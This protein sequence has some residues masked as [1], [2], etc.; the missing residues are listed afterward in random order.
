MSMRYDRIFGL[1]IVFVMV[2]S[3]AGI[4]VYNT[5]DQ[6]ENQQNP[7]SNN[8]DSFEVN[9]FYFYEDT[10]VDAYVAL[11]TDEQGNALN[12]PFRTDPRN[13]SH[14]TI[15]TTALDSLVNAQKVYFTFDPNSDAFDTYKN[16]FSLSLSEVGRLIPRVN[17]YQVAPMTALT[18]DI[19]NDTSDDEIPI[20]TC[21]DATP[22]APVVLF[23]IGQGNAV[24]MDGACIVISGADGDELIAVSDKFGM[25]LMGLTV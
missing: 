7:L 23:T 17:F 3:I 14:I 11:V 5:D 2:G 25:W 10:S 16:Q 1:F 18:A 12:V 15:E 19:P 8:P 13:V 9:G 6:P 22:T 24:K 4:A 21:A 20:K